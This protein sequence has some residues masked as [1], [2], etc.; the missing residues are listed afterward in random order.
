MTTQSSASAFIE[1]IK[2]EYRAVADAE[3]SALPHAIKCGEFLKLAK[4]NLKAER[5]GNWSDWL[6]VNCPEIAQETASLYMRLAEHKAKV[7]KAK[8]IREARDLLPKAKRRGNRNGNQQTPGISNG[9][10]N[11]T[12][13]AVVLQPTDAGEIIA[14]I[15]DDADKLEEAAKASI[16]KLA[17]EKVCDVLISQWE[18]SD[19]R[20][21]A[22]RIN[23]HLEKRQAL[24]PKPDTGA[25]VRRSF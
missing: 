24:S 12:D 15:Q 4:E 5:G 19:L 1:Q 13:P 16:V 11:S 9:V 8:S 21:L 22:K 6:G 3:K 23:A 17:P 2:T 18:D 10:T 25:D 20:E 14:N 7:G